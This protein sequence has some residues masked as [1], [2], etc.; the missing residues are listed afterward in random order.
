MCE[1]MCQLNYSQR[2]SQNANNTNNNN[3]ELRIVKIINTK[4]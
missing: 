2:I 3:V 1:N 4:D